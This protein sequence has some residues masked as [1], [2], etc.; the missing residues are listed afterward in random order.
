MTRLRTVSRYHSAKT[1][2]FCVLLFGLLL[3]GCSGNNNSGRGNERLIPAVEAVQARYGSLPLTERLSGVVR[4]KNQ[5]EL[6]PQI[7]AAIVQVYV[8]N[9][10][11]VSSGQPLVRLRDTEFREQLKQA[12]ASYQ[13]TVAQSKQAEA[14]FQRTQADFE[15]SK[16]L[17]E[18]DLISPTEL[19]DVKTEAVAAEANAELARARVEQAQASVDERKE[20]LSKT[21]VRAPVEGSVGNRNAEVGMLVN[22]N[23]RLFTLGKLDS[24]R[25]QVVLTDRMLSYIKEDQRS[26]ISSP[27]L[28][29]GSVEAPVARISPFLHP[30]AHS[31]TAE[32]DL[33]NPE[34]AL[35]PG[36]FVTVDIFHGESEKATLVPLSALYENPNTGSVGVFVSSEPLSSEPV[37]RLD[38]PKGGGLTEPVSFEF[39]PVEVI[40]KGS[41]SA[42]VSGIDPESWVVTIGQDLFGSDSG[43]ARVRPVKWEWVEE[44]Q[45][46]QREDLLQEIIKRQRQDAVDTS[47]IGALPDEG[48][49]A[50]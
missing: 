33:D 22:P 49:N 27:T 15:R 4:A 25:I 3:A 13:I 7:S 8:E 9:G 6:Y 45:R 40:A 44:L 17:A 46:L 48:G 11:L 18:K 14:E 26:E 10:D 37:A 28:P 34:H 38:N 32:I 42:G 19:E 12:E 31:T 30:V 21:I 35:K 47:L 29:F 39:V 2:F 50:V 23:T 16:A 43:Q 20:E 5:V 24:I 36:M 41:M 1:A